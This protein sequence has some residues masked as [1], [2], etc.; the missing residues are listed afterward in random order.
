MNGPI[1]RALGER[2]LVLLATAALFVLAVPGA[3][4]LTTDN[5]PRVWFLSDSPEVAAY[6]R[7]TAS[8]GGDEGYRI[9]LSGPAL[10]TGTGLAY[11]DRLERG[12][13]T[14]PGVRGV[15]SLLRH[16]RAELAEFPPARPAELRALC[17]ANELD[18][19]MGWVAED[20][21][22]ASLLV[23]T[24]S[25]ER[26]EEARLA[27]ELARRIAAPPP[28]V[29]TTM[30]GTRSLEFALDESSGEVGRVFFPLLV[31]FA[32][33]VLAATFRD[34]G[35][36]AVPLAHVAISTALVLGAMGWAGVRLNLVLVILP[37]L[38]VVVA[39]GSALHVQIP[40]RA[41]EASGSPVAAA[42]AAVYR[43]KGRALLWT[44]FSTVVGFASL[45]ATPVPPVRTLGLWAGAGLAVQTLGIFTW[46]P[47]LLAS[48]RARR[49]LP[50]RRLE[51]RLERFGR[52]VATAAGRRRGLVLSLYALT[53]LVC[54]LGL[55]RLTRE[56][57]ALSYLPKTHPV[58][59][60]AEGLEER[61]L[62]VSTVELHLVAPPGASFAEPDSLLRLAELARR[63]R[64]LP[65][66]LGGASAGD[67][68]T[69]LGASSPLAALATP[70]ELAGDGLALAEADPD[71]R[72]ALARFLTDDRREARVTLFVAHAGYE[73]IDRLAATAEAEARR[74]LPAGTVV[75]A[76]GLLRVLLAIQRYL[77]TTLAGSLA[78]TL[79]ILAATFYLL[80]GSVRDTL[81]ALVPNVWPVL[82]LLGGM[83]WI[84][85][86]LDVAT[87]MVASIVLGLVVDDTIHTLA[88]Y[89]ERRREVGGFEAVAD[90]LE[91]T[92]PAYLLTGGILA[93]GFGV[94]ALSRFEPIARFGTLSAATVLI[95]VVADLLLVPALFARD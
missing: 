87:A 24:A 13:G 94:C 74:L 55:G 34:L 80:L 75:R 21:A 11:L 20:G 7:F 92:A 78:L 45:A 90:K 33:A 54:A 42:V 30:F 81:R 95:A 85:A 79:P 26:G 17:L 18:R 47:A 4:R 31:L 50:E 14:L 44:G 61:G 8:F 15:S 66:V 52:L 36:V 10:W 69:D 28:G 71:G 77:L 25:L 9:A 43:E 48:T 2:R 3:L 64:A 86:P 59:R 67:L 12:I 70:E 91:R 72:R 41:L 83:G 68:A 29:A 46:Y 32:V 65:G 23:E 53:A 35:G 73:A 39:L 84:G 62:G 56:S 6:R 89:R 51:A 63:L 76:T 1:G 16:H 49:A 58:R 93:A 82:A 19:A 37:P 38:V 5:S 57:D 22:A 88:R 40:V 27:A 60:A